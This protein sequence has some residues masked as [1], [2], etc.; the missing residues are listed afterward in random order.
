MVTLMT[1]VLVIFTLTPGHRV[2]YIRNST[3]LL[4]IMIMII[5]S[6][7]NKTYV[8]VLDICRLI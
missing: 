1:G 3:T 6:I 5:I 8:G 7:N 4:I 2:N